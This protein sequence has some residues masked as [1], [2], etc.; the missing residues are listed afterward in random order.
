MRYKRALFFIK[1]L[2]YRFI[3]DDLF[4][5]AAQVTYFLLLSVL[6]FLIFLISLLSFIPYV[7]FQENIEL[8]VTLLPSNAYSTVQDIVYDA[9]ANSSGT[10]L[11]F[12]MIF[13]LWSSSL[14]VSALIR[15]INRAYDQQETRPFWKVI[16]VSIYFNLELAFVIV[17]S[18]TFII[19]G[20]YLGDKFGLSSFIWN[21][22]R[23]FI[24]FI[25]TNII[26]ISFYH[27]TPNRRLKFREVLP[28]AIAAS[29][30]WVFISLIFAYYAN[31]L[32]NYSKIYGSLGGIFALLTWIYL[33]SIIILLGAE[34]NASIC[35]LKSGF[36]KVKQIKF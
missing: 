2:Y 17:F 9:L 14:G 29:F 11:S 34:I 23:N 20:K 22:I 7:N 12:G 4:S 31:N 24:A 21:N 16:I 10:T 35:F 13:T 1:D 33:S 27:N 26:F 18:L 5:V 3:E 28:G 8:F 6:P 36:K 30:G 19:F 25:T 15:G 32:G